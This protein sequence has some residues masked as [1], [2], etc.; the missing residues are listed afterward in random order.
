MKAWRTPLV[1]LL[2]GG[3]FLWGLLR[4][5]DH[6]PIAAADG[7]TTIRFAHT[8]LEPGI[9]EAY[10]AIIADYEALHP[11]VRVEQIAV[12][13]RAWA[14]WMRTRLVGDNAPD[15]LQ[16]ITNDPNPIQRYY[17]P[18]TR[19]MQAPNPYNAG[20][21]LEGI[22]W[23]DTFIVPGT[24]PPVFWPIFLDYYGVPQ[25]FF[26][27][28]VLYNRT[29]WREW[30]GRDTP[31]RDYRE[32][33]TA[34]RRIRAEAERRQQAMQPVAGSRFNAPMLLN[35]LFATVMQAHLDDYD[36]RATFDLEFNAA[37]SAFAR[38]VWSVR[39]P[40]FQA[41]LELMREA[42]GVF[43]PGFLQAERDEALFLFAQERALMLL[44]NSAEFG[45][46]QDDVPFEVGVFQIP[47][48]GPDDPD[49][50]Q[51]VTGE[52]SEANIPLRAAFALTQQSAA[53]E[54]AMDFM[55]YLTSR[56]V[57][58]RF[59]AAV[60]WVP[61]VQ[62]VTPSPEVAAFVPRTH[63]YPLGTHPGIGIEVNAYWSTLVFD[64]FGADGVERVSAAL[65]RAYPPLMIQSINK[66]AR[67]V[68]RAIHHLER[69]ILAAWLE[70]E[71]FPD[72]AAKSSEA[73][74]TQ[75]LLELNLAAYDLDR[76]WLHQRQSP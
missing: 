58:E 51:F 3:V 31:P 41:G 8:Q 53:P 73:R 69:T 62:G 70:P 14:A 24:E 19:W 52:F 23:V 55:L 12:P 13:L 71:A 72:L 66:E 35:T 46:I 68:P 18:I 4:Q 57:H 47:T 50:G 54:A 61:I 30:T 40:A 76:A 32:F 27:S 33:I 20:T 9:R 75:V 5:L 2:L 1:L 11:H 10:A 65:E 36:Y 56:D 48:P 38:G 37:T 25:T 74:E 17:Q 15:L 7:R 26:T 22:P 28:R 45:A 21:P 34:A 67:E 6:R 39:D 63:G 60:G 43:Q 49:Y 44:S 42:G 16:L 29:R 64:L 59:S